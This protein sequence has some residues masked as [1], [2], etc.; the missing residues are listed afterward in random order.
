MP[1]NWEID[2]KRRERLQV[3]DELAGGDRRRLYCRIAVDVS[4]RLQEFRPR[5]SG[6]VVEGLVWS[7]HCTLE[8]HLF[9][10]AA[11]E[12]SLRLVQEGIPHSDGVVQYKGKSGDKVAYPTFSFVAD[13]VPVMLVVFPTD[14]IRQAPPSPVERAAVTA[15]E[16]API[17]GPPGSRLSLSPVTNCDVIAFVWSGIKLSRSTDS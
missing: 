8:L 4:E 7:D 5:V 16:R 3:F 9:V 15:F 11:E 14:G 2:R 6:E 12:V 13:E 1:A 10:D 17:D